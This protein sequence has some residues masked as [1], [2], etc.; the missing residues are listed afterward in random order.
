MLTPALACRPESWCTRRPQSGRL[1]TVVTTAPLADAA[2]VLEDLR[3]GR[4]VGRAV[5]IP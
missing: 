1:R 3:A 4:I 5:L 2:A